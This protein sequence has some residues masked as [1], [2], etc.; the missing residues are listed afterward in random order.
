M[1]RIKIKNFQSIGNIDL[2]I[3]GFTVIVGKSDIGKSAVIRS[4]NAALSNQAGSDFIKHGQKKTSV[5]I[6]YKDLK[7]HWEKGDTSTYKVNGESFTKLN[8]A[9]PKPLMDA[10]FSKIDIG[11][12][13][14][15]PLVASQFEPLFLLD[16]PGSVITDVL[17]ALYKLNTISTADDK[18]QKALKS[19]KTLLKTREIDLDTIQK[20]LDLYKNFDSIKADV[21]KLSDMEKIVIDLKTEI[22]LIESYEHK[23]QEID[24]RMK[25][26]SGANKAV[27]PDI[28]SVTGSMDEL[29]WL[30]KKNI[31]LNEQVTSVRALKSS[32][33]VSIPSYGPLKDISDEL[34]LIK[35]WEVSVKNS[36]SILNNEKLI[37]S[38]TDL[39]NLLSSI[40]NISDMFETVKSISNIE[41]DFIASAT[42]TR[43]VRDELRQ[44]QAELEKANK[45]EAEER[46]RLGV[47]PVCGG[48]L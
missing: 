2:T 33:S 45:E 23:L 40:K 21:K 5:E 9:I 7:I 34:S 10:G 32:C 1:T 16:K 12:Q 35:S 36:T 47:C 27:I 39:N 24:K 48:T 44:I 29:N 22:S 4:I 42:S 3:D 14:L 8:R 20:K 15:S 28:K 18:C 13:K 41:K 25:V 38:E 19:S 17:S 26:L 37:P 11:D 30:S 43:A 46:K 6:D 31:E